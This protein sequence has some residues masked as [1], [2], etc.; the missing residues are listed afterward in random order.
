AF[1]AERAR[2]EGLDFR[3]L[4][5]SALDETLSDVHRLL[6]DAGTL[7]L[8]AYG[9]LLAVLVPLRAALLLLKG[10]QA[11]RIQHALL[12]AIEDVESAGPGRELV[13]VAQ[14]FAHDAAARAALQSG[15]A[16]PHARALPEGP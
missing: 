11:D 8:Q 12:S 14:A 7:L 3:I 5:A 10:D 6:D 13:H 1:E 15:Q 4:A 9:T 2:N 16:I